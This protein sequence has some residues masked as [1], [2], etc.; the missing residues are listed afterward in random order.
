M[1]CNCHQNKILLLFLQTQSINNSLMKNGSTYDQL[2]F[3][4]TLNVLH[5]FFQIIFLAAIDSA[6][7]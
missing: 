4:P 2:C 7:F 6:E 3:F 5:I 1:V